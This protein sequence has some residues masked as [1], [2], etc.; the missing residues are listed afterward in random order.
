S[1]AVG[2]YYTMGLSLSVLKGSLAGGFQTVALISEDPRYDFNDFEG[3]AP[4][5]YV[6]SDRLYILEDRII[7]GSSE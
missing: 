6:I 5:Y 1:T 3:C 2:R 4:P 7:T